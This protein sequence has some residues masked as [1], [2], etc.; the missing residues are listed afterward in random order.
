MSGP[1]RVLLW[2][3][4]A[5][6]LW[7]LCK[8]GR[9]RPSVDPV[10]CLCCGGYLVSIV[11]IVLHN[12]SSLFY[13]FV[14]VVLLVAPNEQAKSKQ[15]SCCCRSPEPKKG[16]V[17][18]L[19]CCLS[20]H[21]DGS[22][23][24]RQTE[25]RYAR[26]LSNQ[27]ERAAVEPRIPLGRTQSN[28]NIRLVFQ[29]GVSPPAGGTRP[30]CGKVAAADPQQRNA[31]LW[32]DKLTNGRGLGLQ[33][34]QLLLDAA[35]CQRQTGQETSELSLAV[36]RSW[37]GCE[38][39][40]LIEFDRMK[41]TSNSG[42]CSPQGNATEFNLLLEGTDAGRV[43]LKWENCIKHSICINYIATLISMAA[44]RSGNIRGNHP[45]PR[46]I[47][48]IPAESE[49]LVLRGFSHSTFNRL[50]L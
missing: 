24:A 50:M 19:F 35:V 2:N 27:S 20:E 37:S 30:L 23:W 33:G 49:A 39:S 7:V 40:S 9:A 25:N 47:G 16:E 46:Q 41:A 11:H 12:A 31:E 34:L 44:P 14:L 28:N 36:C 45:N 10:C 15:R 18:L 17:L 1:A 5:F 32:H 22:L 21:Q 38:R 29:A 13:F 6:G 3:H 8:L 4:L 42:Y 48:W 26:Y 43:S